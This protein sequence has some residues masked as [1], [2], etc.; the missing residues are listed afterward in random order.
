[1]S[2]QAMSQHGANAVALTAAP[3]SIWVHAPE[4]VTVIVGILGCLWYSII[5]TEKILSWV[6]KKE[7]EE[8]PEVPERPEIKHH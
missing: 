5:I 1:M 8:N 4:V 2:G 3:V 7:A 6:K